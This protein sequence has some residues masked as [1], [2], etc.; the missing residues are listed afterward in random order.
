[1]KTNM[2]YAVLCVFFLFS[3]ENESLESRILNASAS[4]TLPQKEKPA[5]N[6]DNEPEDCQTAFAKSEEN[7]CFLEDGFSRWGW[8]LGPIA[9]GDYEYPV[10]SGAGQCSTEKGT[11]VGTAIVSYDDTGVSVDFEMENGYSVD[12]L[13]IYAG[14]TPY[15]TA[16]NGKIT[17][18]PG[19]YY[20]EEGLSGDIYVIVHAEVC[21]SGE[22]DEDDPFIPI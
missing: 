19:Q 9:P 7:H 10:Y 14:T 16:K 21:A 12:D 22:E 11:F 13:H 18:A 4:N 8:Y 3:C 17:V 15:P 2:L 1:M 20:I 5:D 6:D